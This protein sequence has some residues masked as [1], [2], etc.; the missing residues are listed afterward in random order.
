MKYLVDTFRVL[1]ILIMALAAIF[2]THAH[3]HNFPLW[4]V[5]VIASSGGAL[6]WLLWLAADFW[7]PLPPKSI[8]EEW[9]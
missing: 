5:T 4:M 6:A 8:E 9:L 2:G 7:E 1:S 3:L